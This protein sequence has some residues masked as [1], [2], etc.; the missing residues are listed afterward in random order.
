MSKPITSNYKWLL[1]LN[2]DFLFLSVNCDRILFSY[3]Y[4]F[5]TQVKLKIR[6]QEFND[7]LLKVEKPNA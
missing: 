3:C 4:Y 7:I 5:I 2:S 6:L 1:V